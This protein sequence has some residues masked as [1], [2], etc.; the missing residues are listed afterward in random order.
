MKLQ[1][2]V[3]E[4]VVVQ[5]LSM[6][7]L[8]EIIPLC[9]HQKE[10]SSILHVDVMCQ[11]QTD[12]NISWKIPCPREGSPNHHPQREAKQAIQQALTSALTRETSHIV[13]HQKNVVP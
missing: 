13:S 8:Q 6:Y 9:I 2:A 7:N 11:H 4:V 1:D 3:I 5:V 10:I 12:V